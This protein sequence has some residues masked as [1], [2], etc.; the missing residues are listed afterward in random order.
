MERTLEHQPTRQLARLGTLLFA[1][2]TIMSTATSCAPA[3][4][5]ANAPSSAD[6]PILIEVGNKNWS[7]VVVYAIRAGMRWRLGMVTSM[8]ERTFRIP[9]SAG[10]ATGSLQLFVDPIG[11]SQ[12]YATEP[13]NVWPGQRLR[14]TVESRLPLSHVIVR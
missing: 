1:T 13:I 2:M 4:S 10:V 11:S 5:S 6:A 14:F 12:G 7:D 8:S 9:E 3:S